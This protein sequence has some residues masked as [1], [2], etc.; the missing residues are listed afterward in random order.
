MGPQGAPDGGAIFWIAIAAIAV[1]SMYFRHAER[2]TLIRLFSEKGQAVPAELLK[3][4]ERAQSRSRVG[5]G[6][7]LIALSIP[8]ALFFWAMTGGSDPRAGGGPTF[9]PLLALFPLVLGIVFL[10]LGLYQRSHE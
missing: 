2:M 6:I 5:R 4:I 9:M 3:E 1:A 10:G 8:T 7:L